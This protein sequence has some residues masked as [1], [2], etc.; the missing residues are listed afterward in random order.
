MDDRTRV[1]IPIGEPIGG[2]MSAV[3][4]R[5]FEVGRALSRHCAVTFATTA[6]DNDEDHGIP[7]ARCQ[8][9]SEFRE[10]LRMHDVLFTLGLNPDRFLDVIASGIRIIL[11]VYA[12][13]AFEIMECWPEVPDVVMEPL[14]RRMVRWTL[15]QLSRADYII[16]ATEAQKDLW[17]GVMNAAGMLT[18]AESRRDPA[19]HARVGVVPFGVPEARPRPH[20]HPLRDR[21]PGCKPDD[22]LLLWCSKLL[23]WQDPVTLIRAMARLRDQN[24]QVRLVFLGIGEPRPPSGSLYDNAALP[25]KQTRSVADE[26]GLTDRTVFFLNER[27]PYRD[28]GAYYRDANAAVATY[29]DSLETRI[30]M[31]TRLLDYLSAGLP[32]VVSGVQL[33]RDFV[34]EQG[35][36]RVVRPGDAAGLATAILQLKADIEHGAVTDSAFAKARERLLWSRVTAPVVQYCTS[37]QA[38]IR[39]S[40]RRKWSAVVPLAE[41]LARSVGCRLNAWWH[42]V[43]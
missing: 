14:H 3:G 42:G 2:Q 16:C 26:L 29:P 35:L 38:R 9:R 7:I 43:R 15:A 17:L 13:L 28:M 21:I 37:A 18:V 12:P 30:C 4:I 11:D 32:M 40:R 19:W 25:T 1:L 10:L 39:R 20:G 24:A 6:T 31:G 33:Q 36:G 23:A 27:V 41:F 34:E 5:Q 8:T 22:F